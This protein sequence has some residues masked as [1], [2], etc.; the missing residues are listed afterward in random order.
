MIHLVKLFLTHFTYI[1][2]MLVL[3]ATGMGVPLPEDIPLIFSGYLCNPQYSPVHDVVQVVVPIDEDG[4]GI[5]DHFTTTPVR[6]FPHLPIMILAGMMGVLGGDSI[7][8]MIGRRGIDADNIVARHLRKVLHSE[9]RRRVERHFFRHGNLTVFVG[10]FA[11]GLR[12][13]IFGMAGMSR[14]RYRRFLLID[15][16]AALISVPTFIVAG[17]YFA[18]KLDWLFKQIDRI[19]HILLPV[20]ALVLVVGF[21]VHLLRKKSRV[22]Q[23]AEATV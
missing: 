17:Y 18:D 7:I 2:L 20:M 8:F 12:S 4:D 11:P 10:R 3:C 5:P 14:M 15:G 13:L 16:L 6:H 23:T 1:A 21:V 19:K 9:R 22:R